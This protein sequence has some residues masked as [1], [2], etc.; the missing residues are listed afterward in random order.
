MNE[1]A[2]VILNELEKEIK[3]I[4]RSIQ[5]GKAIKLKGRISIKIG[6]EEIDKVKKELF[7]VE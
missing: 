3:S 4:K 2:L 7:R 6:E 1:R 5:G